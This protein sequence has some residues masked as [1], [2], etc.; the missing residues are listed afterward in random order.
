[1]F[2][3]LLG[4]SFLRPLAAEALGGGSSSRLIADLRQMSDDVLTSLPT[5]EEKEAGLVKNDFH[6]LRC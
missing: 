1:V 3:I 2:S 4:K 6:C 5:E